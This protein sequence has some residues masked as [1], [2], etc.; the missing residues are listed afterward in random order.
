MDAPTEREQFL[1]IL[2]RAFE[3]IAAA[4]RIPGTINERVTRI[5]SAEKLARSVVRRQ[6]RIGQIRIAAGG[7]VPPQICRTLADALALV[8]RVAK[9][10]REAARKKPDLDCYS[11]TTPV[12]PLCP[13]RTPMSIVNT[14]ANPLHKTLYEAMDN[15]DAHRASLNTVLNR[16]ATLDSHPALAADADTLLSGIETATPEVHRAVVHALVHGLRDFRA[17]IAAIGE[18]ARA[19]LDQAE[20]STVL[21]GITLT[22]DTERFALRR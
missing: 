15:I 11:H 13:E 22:G 3:R 18:G 20:T 17:I 12:L 16:V 4:A 21:A 7:S 5:N 6:L 10:Y 14:A 8:S 2:Q 19:A 9:K 1:A